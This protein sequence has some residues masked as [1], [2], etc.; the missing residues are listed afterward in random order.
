MTARRARRVLL[1]GLDAA[2][3]ELVERW[4]ADGTLPHL[5]TLR[6]DGAYGRIR[7]SADWLVGSPWP[8]FYTGTHPG[9]H[10][11]YHY[12]GWRPER[13]ETVRPTPDWLPLTPFWRALGG[14]LRVI[15]VDLP[16]TYAPGPF[17][18]VEI[19]GWA[20]HDGLVPPSAYPADLLT[21]A[22][23]EVGPSPRTDEEFVMQPVRRLLAQRDEQCAATQGLADLALALMRA[24]PWDLC[25]VGFTATH[26]CGH[27]LWDETG[28]AGAVS[29]AER[30]EYAGALREVYRACDE[31]V[32]RL[33][34]AAG[35]DA[36]LI[37]FSLHGM[38]PNTC[39]TDVLPEML[40][41][42]LARDSGAGQPVRRSGLKRLR[43]LVPNEWRH[44]VK[45]RLPASVQ[46]RLTAFWRLGAVDW[47]RTRAFP[48]VA[49]LQG[50]IRINLRGREAA[51][52]VEPG[53]D[54]DALCEE[55]SD[56][57]RTFVDADT[58]EPVVRDL[59]RTDALYPGG[60]RLSALPD[61]LVQWAESPVYAQR[62]I[63]SPRFGII[64][65]PAPGANPSGRS[66]N[67][68]PDGFAVVCGPGVA[69]GSALAGG[70][71]LDLAPTVYDA[72]GLAPP[73][74]FSGRP[75]RWAS[76]GG[77]AAAAGTRMPA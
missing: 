2:E 24:D 36:L 5:A 72:L 45:R 37:V 59:A 19:S 14:D 21:W 65:M 25:L 1:I 61:L 41:R 70:H 53:A 18:G 52:V 31:A 3:P 20:T 27:K 69:A 26:R 22:A 42:V 39:R 43:E 75:L 51:G 66:G 46:D 40:R 34:E 67:H 9:A 6:Q 11:F 7:S 10:G 15:A 16:L 64:P 63:A 62:G 13:M 71:V 48:L 30:V 8:T 57:L 49:D 56:G 44:A 23:R 55:I 47:S 33:A 4:T 32:G 74:H 28:V 54:F 76:E 77:G 35:P 68:R 60:E 29:P 58:G 17:G 73:P 50:Y 12:L 38:G